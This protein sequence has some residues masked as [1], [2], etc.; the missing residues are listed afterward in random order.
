MASLRKT[1][2][3]RMLFAAP[4]VFSFLC[5]VEVPSDPSLLDG[6]P[7]S[8]EVFFAAYLI[9]AVGACAVI[10]VTDRKSVV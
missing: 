8:P 6:S 10:V 1:V 5:F 2:S 4:L 3:W 9:G 7:A